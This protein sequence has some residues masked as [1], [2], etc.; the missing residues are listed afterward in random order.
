MPEGE[1][2]TGSLTPTPGTGSKTAPRRSPAAVCTHRLAGS[3]SGSQP[4]LLQRSKGLPDP[5]NYAVRLTARKKAPR[6]APSTTTRTPLSPWWRSTIRNSSRYDGATDAGLTYT[7]PGISLVFLLFALLPP[8]SLTKAGPLPK[9]GPGASGPKTTP[10][11]PPSPQSP[12]HK[13]FSYTLQ[14]RPDSSV[15]RY[16]TR[17]KQVPNHKHQVP[18]GL[19]SLPKHCPPT[20]P[21]AT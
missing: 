9:S 13:A 8:K 17:Y 19:V 1:T 21:R 3:G 5:S 11:F 6:T 15:P 16:K 10:F 7:W 12:V 2:L 18:N 14:T 20:E 4:H